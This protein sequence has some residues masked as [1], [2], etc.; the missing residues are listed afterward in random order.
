MTCLYKP[1]Y[2]GCRHTGLGNWVTET[3]ESTTD[4][5]LT[6]R[7][8]V[9]SYEYYEEPCDGE[10]YECPDYVEESAIKKDTRKWYQC[11]YMNTCSKLKHKVCYGSFAEEM[12]FALINCDNPKKE[13]VEHSPSEPVVHPATNISEETAVAKPVN[14]TP[15]PTTQQA[16]QQNALGDGTNSQVPMFSAVA[17]AKK[18][19]PKGSKTKVK[20]ILTTTEEVGPM[21]YIR[22]P[23]PMPEDTNG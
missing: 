7:Q 9:T 10:K 16:V 19:R 8:S 17:T 5:G 6:G 4:Y 20:P 15:E 1:R 13:I 21:K 11:N 3:R 12:P 23:N 22:Q 18:G 2:G 14:L